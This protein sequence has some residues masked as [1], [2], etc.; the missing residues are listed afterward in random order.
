LL[1]RSL[2]GF[3]M[4]SLTLTATVA[5]AAERVVLRYGV[6]TSSVAVTDLE[7]LGRTGTAPAAIEAQLRATDSS[8]EEVQR[9]LVKEVKIN[10]VLLDRILN[11][12]LGEGALDRIG[13]FIQ[14]P[15][16]GANRQALRSAL[17]L[18]ASDDGRLS[19]LETIQKY[20]TQEVHLDGMRLLKAYTALRKLEK[21]ARQVED[22]IKIF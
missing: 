21:Q 8:P 14:T 1:K 20:P 3:I 11:S 2:F 13:E 15:T 5:P 9:A 10:H 17:V 6:L 12:P 22:V 19:L 18:S 16:G 4:S 7:T